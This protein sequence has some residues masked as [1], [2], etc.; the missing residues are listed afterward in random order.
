MIRRL[1]TRERLDTLRNDKRGKPAM[2]G[3]RIYVALM[4]LLG[5]ALVDYMVGDVVLL[6][7]EGMVLTNRSVLSAGY[8][9]MVVDVHV[10]EGDAV[11]AGALLVQLESA[12]ML[13]DIADLAGRTADLAG[14]ESQLKV[15]RDNIGAVLPLAERAAREN[16]ESIAKLDRLSSSGYASARYRDQTLTAGLDSAGRASDLRSQANAVDDELAL[17]QQSRSRAVDALA[18]LER[19]YSQGSLKAPV[20]GVI[21]AR[22][23]TVGQVVRFG[24]EL[25]QIHGSQAYV[26]AYVPDLYVATPQPGQKVRVSSGMTSVTGEIEKVLPVADALPPEFQNLFRPRQRSRLVRVSLPPGHGFVLQQTVSV[27]GCLLGLCWPDLMKS[28]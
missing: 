26:L 6:R 24:D 20:S 1:K 5:L 4:A 8:P 13:R 25:L 7:G 2:W 27:H 15:R 22:I 16:S 23:P 11:E 28:N 12:D 19:V 9:A 18:R 21:G 14:R 10:K 17:V 3:R